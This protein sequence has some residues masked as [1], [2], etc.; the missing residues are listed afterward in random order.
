VLLSGTICCDRPTS[1][2]RP[3]TFATHDGGCLP[4]V[5]AQFRQSHAGWNTALRA[6]VRAD[7]AVWSI[8]A[9]A[10]LTSSPTRVSPGLDTVA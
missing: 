5:L 4:I 2:R 9:H 7:L 10:N 8:A 3:L 6:P 1:P